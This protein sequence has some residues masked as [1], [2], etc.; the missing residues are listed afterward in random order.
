DDALLSAVSA[1]LHARLM[2][3]RG[4][5]VGAREILEKVE[6]PAGWLRG[7]FDGEA[8]ALGLDAPRA[9]LR[10]DH[11]AQSETGESQRGPGTVTTAQ[12]IQELLEHAQLECAAGD[13]G[14]GRSEVAMA[15]SLGA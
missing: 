1:L 13:V 7:Y 4:D 15:L 8:A 2:R 14:A 6:P 9:V 10:P 11:E 12:R 3:D 5:R